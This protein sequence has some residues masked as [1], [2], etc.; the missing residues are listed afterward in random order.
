MGYGMPSYRRPD[1]EVEVA[2]ASQ[3]NYLSLYIMRKDVLDRFRDNLTTA[4]LGKGCV[5]YTNPDTIDFEVVRDM[6]QASAVAEGR[7]C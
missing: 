7:V 4:R 2:F 1:G 5:R 3:A 6:L